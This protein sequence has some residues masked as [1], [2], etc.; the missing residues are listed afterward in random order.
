[1]PFPFFGWVR[2]GTLTEQILKHISKVA[3]LSF[4]V[5]VQHSLEM[6]E[7]EAQIFL[8]FFLQILDFCYF[9]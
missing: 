3:F 8:F 4:L 2:V 1:M 6:D 7:K 9:I 5:L